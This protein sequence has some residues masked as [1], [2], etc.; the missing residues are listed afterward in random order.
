MDQELP[1]HLSLSLPVDEKGILIHFEHAAG[2]EY[3]FAFFL[4]TGT[5]K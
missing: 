1:S 5:W 2:L 3:D 4:Q